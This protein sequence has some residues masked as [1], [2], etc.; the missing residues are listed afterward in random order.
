MIEEAVLNA[1]HSRQGVD[2]EIAEAERLVAEEK[3]TVPQA[4]LRVI[5]ASG[6]DG[7]AD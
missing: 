2:G 7:S 1:F 4:T 5:E 3:L 6:L